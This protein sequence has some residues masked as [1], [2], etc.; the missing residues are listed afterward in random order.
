M[1]QPTAFSL[2][3]YGWLQGTAAPVRSFAVAKQRGAH[4]VLLGDV[5]RN[6]NVAKLLGSHLDWNIG[7]CA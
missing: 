5:S 4:V 3:V 1:L 7:Y 6:G 2:R